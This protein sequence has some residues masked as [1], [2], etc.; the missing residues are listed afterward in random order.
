MRTP[1]YRL[2]LDEKHS[3]DISEYVDTLSFEDCMSED[4]MV[5]F[6]VNA[7]RALELLDNDKVNTGTKLYFQFGF[8]GEIPSKVHTAIIKDIDTRYGQQGVA[9]TIRAL[10]RG[11]DIKRTSSPK[12][13]K[14]IRSSDIARQ[15]AKKYNLIPVVDSTTKV[16]DSISQ[17]NRSDMEFLQYVANRELNGNY[18]AYIRGDEL[19]FVTRG[20]NKTSSVTFRWGDGD[21][22]VIDFYPKLRE[23]T[24]KKGASSTSLLSYD[25]TNQKV[26][27]TNADNKTEKDATTLG[28]V[29]MVYNGI[30]GEKVSEFIDKRIPQPGNADT[31]TNLANSNKKKGSLKLQGASLT[32][33]GNP[34]LEPNT[35]I[36]MSGTAERHTG[37]WLV[38]KVKHSI[39]SSGYICTMELL[40]NGKKKGGSVAAKK[41]VTVGP[42]KAKDVVL[43]HIDNGQYETDKKERERLTK[44]RNGG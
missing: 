25:T 33:I 18:V 30:V 27:V 14:N 29:K 5:E 36:T 1:F 3:R 38:E 23:S 32:V 15:I 28:Q 43:I 34:K 35:V 24:S 12:I 22:D 40:K 2:Y 39:S 13:W 8:L 16:W 9:V 10:D 41:N 6:K 7:N 21:G 26:Q 44:I 37:N 42:N 4:S 19:Y 31:L 20:L 17:G 11:T